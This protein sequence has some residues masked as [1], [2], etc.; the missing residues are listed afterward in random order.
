MKKILSVM[1]IAIAIIFAENNFVKA[2]DVYVGTS[3]TTGWACY[4]MTETIRETE[5]NQYRSEYHAT[6]KMVTNSGNV[7]YLDYTFF[8]KVT[9]KYLYFRNS[10]G[11]EG[12]VDQYKTPIEYNMTGVIGRYL[13]W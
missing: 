7:K 2:Q 4:V 9:L 5:L 6:L 3:N 10:Q 13:G 11:F 1:L 8:H 12:M